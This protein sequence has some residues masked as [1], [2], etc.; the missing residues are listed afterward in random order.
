[1]KKMPCSFLWLSILGLL[2]PGRLA[3]SVEYDAKIPQLAF[4]A[5]ELK[6]ALG[7]Q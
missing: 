1:M 5:Q 6:D 3:A 7:I 2:L 4:A